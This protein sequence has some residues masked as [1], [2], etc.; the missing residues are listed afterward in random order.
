[1]RRGIGARLTV[2]SQRLAAA[3][4]AA[5]PLTSC[6]S[7]ALRAGSPAP[8]AAPAATQDTYRLIQE[9]DDGY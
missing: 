2:T 1:M 4:T 3:A 9:P 8:P 7:M 6:G 5:V